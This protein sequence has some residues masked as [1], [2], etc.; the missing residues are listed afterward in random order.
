MKLIY[1]TKDDIMNLFKNRSGFSTVY[2]IATALVM[3]HV[4]RNN[5][6]DEEWKHVQGFLHQLKSEGYLLVENEGQDI[7]HEKFSSTPDRIDRYFK[8]DMI[9]DNSDLTKKTDDE[10]R[11]IM[12]SSI[13]NS[14]VPS[15]IYNKANLELKFR[16]SKIDEQKRDIPPRWWE[17]TWVQAIMFI[18]AIAGI[19]GLVALFK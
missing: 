1:P 12:R 5:A 15:S 16:K 17:K 11:E 3:P 2:G 4:P 8:K 6:L 10:L 9:I 14:Y 19:L 13:D 18:G 7:L